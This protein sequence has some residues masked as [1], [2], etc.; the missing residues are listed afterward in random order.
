VRAFG[1][2]LPFHV[3]PLHLIE[4]LGVATL[5]ALL[6]MLAPLVKLLRMPPATL[7]KVFAD[8]R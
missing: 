8:E 3:F 6:A 4:L 1:W 5:A 7:I 2:R